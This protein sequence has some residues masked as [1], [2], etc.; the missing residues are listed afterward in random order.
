MAKAKAAPAARLAEPVTFIDRRYKERTIITPS[1]TEAVI[2]N[3][4]VTTSD[5]D[6]T[7]YLD[8]HAHFERVVA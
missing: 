1:G 7:A 4:R 5:D 6:V 3:H 2:K 8:K